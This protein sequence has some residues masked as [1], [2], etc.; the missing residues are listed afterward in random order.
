MWDV[1]WPTES[2]A[3]SLGW[4]VDEGEGNW[5]AYHDPSVVLTPLSVSLED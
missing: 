1:I 2:C 4:I 5:G 3:F